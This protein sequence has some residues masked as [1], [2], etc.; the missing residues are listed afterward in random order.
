MAD[1]QRA[2]LRALLH[3]LLDRGLIV[4]SVYDSTVQLVNS[5]TDLPDFLGPSV[6]CRREERGHGGA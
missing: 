3:A 2:I 6:C 4:Q 1:T 5:R